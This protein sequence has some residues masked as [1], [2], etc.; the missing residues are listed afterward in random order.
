MTTRAVVLG[1]GGV[2]GIAWETG[3]IVGLADAGVDVRNADLMVG[4]SAGSCVAAQMASGLALDDLFQRQIDPALQAKE[5]AAEIDWPKLMAALGAAGQGAANL[6]DALRRMGALAVSWPTVPETARL[7][8]IASRLPNHGWPATALK[9][10]AVDTATGERR[11]FEKAS[12]VDLIDAAA[13]SCAVP[14]V[15]PPVT[16]GGHRY[17][18]GGVYSNQHADLTAG[19]DV[20]LIVAPSVPV[21]PPV[22]LDTE[23][24]ELKRGGTAV[25]IIPQDAATDAAIAAVGGNL[26]DPSVRSAVAQT[27][28]A[29]GR[30]LA[31]EVARIWG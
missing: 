30:S 18:D 11:V 4:T 20:A 27:G 28:R 26:L 13:A 12:G 7:A 14:G 15:W 16:I 5:I 24:A 23:V 2:S 21:S 22:T 19:Y 9:I 29:Y 3:V 8:V 17:M 31:T 6:T 10:T 25:F 1:G